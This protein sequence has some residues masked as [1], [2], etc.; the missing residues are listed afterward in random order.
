MIISSKLCAHFLN[1]NELANLSGLYQIIVCALSR[2]KIL[3][4]MDGWVDVSCFHPPVGQ[5][6]VSLSRL[7]AWQWLGIGDLSGEAITKEKKL[8]AE[9]CTC[10]SWL[11]NGTSVNQSQKWSLI[12]LRNCFALWYPW[13]AVTSCRHGRKQPLGEETKKCQV[14]VLFT[15]RYWKF[16]L[17]WY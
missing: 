7:A 16:W 2:T 12:S 3:E 13:C 14:C 11:Q 8:C 15:S 17:L 10:S 1:C 4:K 9:V 5:L 6:S